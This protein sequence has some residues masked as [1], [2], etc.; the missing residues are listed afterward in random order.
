MDIGRIKAHITNFHHTVEQAEENRDY[1][2]DYEAPKNH[3]SSNYSRLTTP[4]ERSRP[5]GHYFSPMC[6]SEE[7]SYMY[8]YDDYPDYDLDFY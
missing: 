4:I 3:N 6:D 8:G 5:D 7:D 1:F 2:R